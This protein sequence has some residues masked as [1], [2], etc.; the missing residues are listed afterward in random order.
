[1][2]DPK[3]DDVTGVETTGH[4]W[5]GI[6]ELNNPLPS[7]WLWIFYATVVWSIGFTIAYPAWPMLT[8]ATKGMLGYS[9]RAEV[10]KEIEK[11]EAALATTRAKIKSSSLEEI[12][13]NTELFDFAVARGGGLFKLHCSTCHGSNAAGAKGYP[14]LID[15]DWIWGGSLKEIAYTISHGIR[16]TEEDGLPTEK[17]RASAMPAFG[18]QGILKRGEVKAV[19]EYVLKLS[20]QDHD[21]KL[22]AEGEPIYAKQCVRCHGAE[23]KGDR[24]LGAPNLSDQIW[25]YGGD[26]KTV[27]TTIYH[28]RAGAMPAWLDKL[29]ETSVKELTI[30]VH[31]LGGGE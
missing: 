8:E 15:D 26:R 21:P 16:Q 12:R 29:D 9:S 1:M 14:S 25:L 4:E 2:A 19:A 6:Q 27:F 13:K 7:W 31:S 30:Y 18:A 17:A 28:S 24:S 11:A 5:D 10:A 23:G 22:A 3:K 20:K